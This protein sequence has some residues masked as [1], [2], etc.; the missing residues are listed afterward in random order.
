MAIAGAQRQTI[1]LFQLRYLRERLLGEGSLSL[2][3]VQYDAFE[4]IADGQIF[5]FR[6]G[7][8][9]L[10]QPFLD[11]DSRLHTLD[12]D[13]RHYPAQNAM[14]P[15]YISTK[16]GTRLYAAGENTGGRKARCARPGYSSFSARIGRWR[17]RFPVAWN[18]ALA[19]AAF[20]PTMPISPM[21]LIPSGFT[22]ASF[23]A[24]MMIS[25][26]GASAFTGIK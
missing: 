25:I 11:T 15:K 3:C 26:E 21:P 17:M 9:H 8:Q 12:F 14:V 5:E 16:Q 7:L 10:Q 23:S 6:Q 18:T 2:K 20:M 1:D 22:R 24:T 4:Q 19:T 13:H